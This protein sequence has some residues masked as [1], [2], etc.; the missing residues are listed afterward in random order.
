MKRDNSNLMHR[1]LARQ[2]QRHLGKDITP[3]VEY[4]ALFEAISAHYEEEDRER[5]LLENALEVS[6]DELTEANDRLRAQN[7]EMTRTMLD[8][9][10][11]GVYAT[12]MQGR[13]VFINASF[14][15]IVGWH[16]ADLIGRC[17]EEIIF[18]SRSNE[19]SSRPDEHFLHR[20]L[21]EGRFV[22]GEENCRHRDGRRIP[23]S[24]RANPL[25][26]NGKIIGALVSIIDVTERK[27]ST[28]LIWKQANFDVLTGLPNRRMFY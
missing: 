8:T 6:S 21:T 28:E 24:F 15:A 9:L 11:E 25:L 1:L 17:V 7:A 10:S 23:V 5:A 12:D 14:E 13:F 26:Q 4:H 19:A 27:K 22:S 16:E 2:L 20:V 3:S 18:A